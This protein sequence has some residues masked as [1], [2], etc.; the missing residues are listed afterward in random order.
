MR[1][2]QSLVGTHQDL[3]ISRAQRESCRECH[4]DKL[5][6]LRVGGLGL[7]CQGREFRDDRFCSPRLWV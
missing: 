2:L 3:T 4:A 5:V 7:G 6:A 1:A